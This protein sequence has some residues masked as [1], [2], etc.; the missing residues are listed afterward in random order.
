M[1]AMGIISG[2]MGLVGT[3]VSA[4]A[5][6]RQAAALRNQAI[7]E[8][9]AAEFNAQQQEM[10]AME[11]RAAAQRKAFDKREQG[12]LALS[13]LQ[14]R[15]AASGG[16]AGINDPTV[17][18]LASDIGGKAEYM[19]LGDMFV[20]E[21]RGRAHEAEADIGRYI[22]ET[23]ARSSEEKAKATEI[24]AIGSILGGVGGLFGKF[25]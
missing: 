18:S 23:K 11:E 17:I 3:I 14:A 16:G 22:G 5:A 2:V 8:R 4:A 10:R 20:G 9:Q 6:G 7:A 21:S 25:G 19:A 15:A 24:G 12:D 13:K 1:A